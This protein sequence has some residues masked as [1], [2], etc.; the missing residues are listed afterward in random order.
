L[1]RG[2]LVGLLTLMLL[3]GI[4]IALANASN[5]Y[6]VV[7]VTMSKVNQV[8][9]IRATTDDSNVKQVNFTWYYP[10][11]DGGPVGSKVVKGN[12][13][14]IGTFIPD[15]AG[16]WFVTID[17]QDENGKTISSTS[18]LEGIFEEGYLEVLGPPEQVVPEVPLVG[19]L[20]VTI[21][22]LLGFGYYKKRKK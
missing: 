4:Y 10:Y 7:Q 11:P 8:W 16:Y 22:M 1:R 19:T 15:Q 18:H 5:T 17:F 21:A 12:S 13:P 14:F 6:Q 20:G 9:T 2:I 3:L